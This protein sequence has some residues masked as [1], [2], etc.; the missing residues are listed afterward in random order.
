MKALIEDTENWR[1]I[2]SKDDYQYLGVFPNKQMQVIYYSPDC[3][4]LDQSCSTD[5]HFLWNDIQL[6]K[7]KNYSIFVEIG[8]N[9]RE[10]LIYRCAPCNGVKVCPQSDC[11]FVAPISRT[12]PCP[13]HPDA[14]L[15]RS[16]ETSH[17]CPVQFA[18]TYPK[19]ID[20]DDRRWI[21]GFIRQQKA[22]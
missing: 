11:S 1:S 18:Y 17:K 15:K 8:S 22:P 9:A 16:N 6:C 14:P 7:G 3:T 19:D 4:K 20:Q 21:M 10:E 12:R 13:H 2:S 5:P